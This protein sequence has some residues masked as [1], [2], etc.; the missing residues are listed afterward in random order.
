MSIV[1]SLIRIATVVL[2]LMLGSEL[3]LLGD[4]VFSER[5]GHGH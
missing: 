1:S 4:A 3:F 5:A 2:F